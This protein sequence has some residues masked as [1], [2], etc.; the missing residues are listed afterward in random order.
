MGG[1]GGHLTHLASTRVRV[2]LVGLV[3]AIGA[4]IV[5]IGPSLGSVVELQVATAR[6]TVDEFEPDRLTAPAA[7][8]I[9]LRFENRSSGPH[10]FTLL[11]PLT[12]RTGTIVEP[13]AVE[14]LEFETAALGSYPFVC[15]IHPGMMGV[16]IVE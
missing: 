16:L 9:V 6:G 14:T 8:R 2:G 3:V 13:G 12:V 10:N 1:I 5:A 11:E 15:T 7:T 4:V